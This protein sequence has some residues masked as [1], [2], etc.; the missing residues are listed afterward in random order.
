M[1]FNK[2]IIYYLYCFIPISLLT[3]YML[4]E[5]YTVGGLTPSLF[6]SSLVLIIL[7]WYIYR[8]L[9]VSKKIDKYI[10][11]SCIL[12]IVFPVYYIL[13]TG[14]NYILAEFNYS[15]VIL[16][17]IV[18][19]LYICNYSKYTLGEIHQV[20]H[21]LNIILVLNLLI[22]ASLN[23]GYP[24]YTSAGREIGVKGFLYGGN[25]ASVLALAVLS[26][27][28]FHKKMKQHYKLIY[29]IISFYAAYLVKTI[30]SILAPFLM[31]IFFLKNYRKI[32]TITTIILLSIIAFSFEHLSQELEE[33]TTNNYRLER[34][35]I[36]NVSESFTDVFKLY[37]ENS[38]R[39]Q[40]S[41]SQIGYQFN[42]P[43]SLIFG[44]GRSGQIEFY[45]RPLLDFSGM[46][47]FD[48]LFRYGILGVVLITIIFVKPIY[49][50]IKR[51]GLDSISVPPAIIILYGIFGGYVFSSLTT[52]VYL[53]IYIGALKIKIRGV[54]H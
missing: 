54:T 33:Y 23:V 19:L 5:G 44:I 9:Y 20:I 49:S 41:S 35:G 13:L 37:S 15:V 10:F 46:D 34:M 17:S 47:I 27:Y 2:I 18:L 25:T 53:S 28:V 48:L 12:F 1:K 38:R 32:F 14:A 45:N 51:F 6:I 3:G 8:R 36:V 24:S 50:Y 31:I 43:T 26:H 7:F 42:N 52:L 29:I 4:R 16:F 30:A 11:Y 40:D 22:S 39:I 21:V